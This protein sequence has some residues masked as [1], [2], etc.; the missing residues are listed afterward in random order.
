[1]SQSSASNETGANASLSGHFMNVVKSFIGSNYLAI[2]H[3]FLLGGIYFGPAGMSMIAILTGYCCTLL[4]RVRQTL[5]DKGGL[6]CTTYGQV[7]S[8]VMGGSGYAFVEAALL[9]TQFGFCVGYMVF[10]GTALETLFGVTFW[11]ACLL[12]SGPLMVVVCVRE[13]SAF[14]SCSYIAN[15]ALL[16]SFV[17]LIATNIG[18]IEKHGF[19]DESSPDLTK[20]PIF[21]GVIIAC[22]EGI[23][24]VLPVEG[25][26]GDLSDVYPKFLWAVMAIMSVLFS[27]FGILGVGNYGASVCGIIL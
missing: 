17:L 21:F 18:G 25:A 8:S 20:L 6:P 12:L 27:L 15:F 10:M 5:R 7:T 16:V 3:V 23:G 9:L 19:S 2:P 26:M 24:T 4:V 13:L 14:T 22:F 1:M 11:Q